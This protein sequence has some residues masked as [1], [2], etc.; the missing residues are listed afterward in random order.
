MCGL[1]FIRLASIVRPAP[2]ISVQDEKSYAPIRL[3]LAPCR[4]PPYSHFQIFSISINFE[5]FK[6]K[7]HKR[8]NKKETA[9]KTKKKQ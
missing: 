8:K 2:P 4:T 6:S 3:A 7:K 1:L 9:E 5:F